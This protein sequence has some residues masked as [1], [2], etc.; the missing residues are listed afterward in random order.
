MI[1]WVKTLTF[2]LSLFWIV[3]CMTVGTL[4]AWDHL[5]PKDTVDQPDLVV[6]VTFLPVLFVAA[7]LG[8]AVARASRPWKTESKYR[9]FR[10]K[11]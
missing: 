10:L 11:L 1:F 6:L 9:S 7:L 3:A 8:A 5:Q 2:A 4:I